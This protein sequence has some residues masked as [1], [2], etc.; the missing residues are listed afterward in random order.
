MTENG[1][2]LINIGAMVLVFA[3]LFYLLFVWYKRHSWRIRLRQKAEAEGTVVQAY[4]YKK[5]LIRNYEKDSDNV[6]GTTAYVKYAYD[7]DGVTYYTKAEFYESGDGCTVPNVMDVYY[8]RRN[9]RKGYVAAVLTETYT[10]GIRIVLLIALT[11][12]VG[13]LVNLLLRYQFP[14]CFS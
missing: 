5:R 2:V 13:F 7:V 8:D 9:P 1:V 4:V 6:E 10:M 14:E 3:V 11:I 12:L